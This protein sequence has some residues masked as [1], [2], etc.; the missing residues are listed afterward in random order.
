MYL[1]QFV[2]KQ[3]G[4][5][6]LMSRI[7]YCIE[8]VSG[9]CQENIKKIEKLYN[10]VLRFVY[11]LKRYDHVSNYSILFLGSTFNTYVKQRLLMIFYK[12]IQS[13]SPVV[14][15]TSFVFSHSTRH[16]QIVIPRFSSLVFER[17]FIVRVARTWNVLP[18]Q[19]RT[20]VYPSSVFKNKYISFT[21]T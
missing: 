9:T 3:L 12:I 13:N 10:M 20:F 7:S 8:V 19:L 2:R 15:R 14:L 16:T 11:R 5:A 17:S 4:F 21:A 18:V 6:L 1:H